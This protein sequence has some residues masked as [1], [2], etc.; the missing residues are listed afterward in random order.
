[1]CSDL[2]DDLILNV[3]ALE[4]CSRQLA[5]PPLMGLDQVNADRIAIRIANQP[6]TIDV[7][8]MSELEYEASLC[9]FSLF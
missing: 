9:R 7:P 4:I 3:D 6:N 2:T 8:M 1:M 5:V